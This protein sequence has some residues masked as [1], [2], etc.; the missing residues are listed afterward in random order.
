MFIKKIKILICFLL[1]ALPAKAEQFFFEGNEILILENGNKLQSKEGVKIT[2]SDNIIITSE[3]FD[4]DK[5]K[6]ILILEGNV[7]IN[8]RNNQTVIN[9]NK[10]FYDRKKEKIETF[11]KT[12]IEIIFN[13]EKYN[14]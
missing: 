11:D 1:I 12:I 6:Q 5:I 3:K 7:N 9:A 8:D 4:Y 10:I 14:T 2:S 13:L